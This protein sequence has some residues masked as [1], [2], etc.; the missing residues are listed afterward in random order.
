[1]KKDKLLD[2]FCA[3]YLLF[4]LAV[5]VLAVIGPKAGKSLF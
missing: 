2:I 3:A 4:I 1:M 5:Y